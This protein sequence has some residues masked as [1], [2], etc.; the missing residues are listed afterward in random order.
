MQR[1]PGDGRDGI[2]VRRLFDFIE[3]R[4]LRNRNDSPLKN[5]RSSENSKDVDSEKLT[6]SPTIAFT[7]RLN[8]FHFL[9]FFDQRH[10]LHV[11]YKKSNP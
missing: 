3:N 2:E 5:L 9:P 4:I 11:R 10:R 1:Y 6:V 7:D 8:G